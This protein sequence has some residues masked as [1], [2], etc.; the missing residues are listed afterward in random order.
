MYKSWGNISLALTIWDVTMCDMACDR[1]T[2]NDRMLSR[3]CHHWLPIMY[4]IN[5][6]YF[7]LSSLCG[8]F[9][10]PKRLSKYTPTLKWLFI[11]DLI[12]RDFNPIKPQ[13]WYWQVQ[14]WNHTLTIWRL[15]ENWSITLSGLTIVNRRRMF[16]L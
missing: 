5:I 6:W 16:S 4:S 12:W 7:D 11:H 2:S 13:D 10:F 1:V 3:L 9:P 14:F 15:I 8:A